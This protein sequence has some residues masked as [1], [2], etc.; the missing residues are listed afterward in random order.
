MIILE[1]SLNGPTFDVRFHAACSIKAETEK[2]LRAASIF[3]DRLYGIN[4]HHY[5]T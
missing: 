3:T 5:R 2:E 1:S 4:V